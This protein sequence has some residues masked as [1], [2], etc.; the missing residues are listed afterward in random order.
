MSRKAGFKHSDETKE[1]LREARQ[2]YLEKNGTLLGISE[3]DNPQEYMKVY[4]RMWRAKNPDYYKSRY[5]KKSEVIGEK[6]VK[7]QEIQN[8]WNLFVARRN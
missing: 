8:A 4:C 3:K 1:K 2:K 5:K 7:L 6:M